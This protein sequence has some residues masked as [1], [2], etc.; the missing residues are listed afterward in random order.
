MEPVDRERRQVI[1]FEEC[2]AIYDNMIE[3]YLGMRVSV[4]FKIFLPLGLN[5]SFSR[6]K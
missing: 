5:L 2:F 4:Q 6:E 1:K 3:N